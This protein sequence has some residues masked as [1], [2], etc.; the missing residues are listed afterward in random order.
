MPAPRKPKKV[1]VQ[2]AVAFI[3]AVVFGI[4]ALIFG[5]SIISNA[6]TAAKKAE[7]EAARAK[8][9][10]EAERKRIEDEKNKLSFKIRYKSVQAVTDIVPGQ[11]IT[12]EMVTLV[13]DEER[14]IAGAM[15]SLSQVVGRLVKSPVMQ[16]DTLEAN[17]LLDSTGFI[18]VD[19]GMRAITIRASGISGLNGALSP[20]M[21][22][23][24]LVTITSDERAIT[25]TLL[26]DIQVIGTND[27]NTSNASPASG[28]AQLKQMRPSEPGA[29]TV[30]VTP[31]QAEM[32]TLANQLGAFHLTLRNFHDRKAAK[33]DGSDITELLTGLPTS[34]LKKELPK[35]PKAPESNN[36]HNVNYSP[37]GG[38]LPA[39]SGPGTN[40]SKFSM[41]I[42][43]GTGTETVDFQQ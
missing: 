19:P 5:F 22:V 43:R 28:I 33:V 12:K 24:I 8:A 31:K 13:E 32:L 29:I 20:G 15:N 40:T 3:V 34:G 17:K 27:N 38:N 10:V 11:P 41:Q 18:N 36:F 7:D 6:S 42:Y 4:G 39:P 26:Q 16:G 35:P 30:A 14:P 21:H 23:D 25:R 2:F 37:G 9:E 1:F